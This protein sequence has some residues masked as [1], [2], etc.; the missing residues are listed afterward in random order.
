M[1]MGGC[2]TIKRGS[3]ICILVLSIISLVGSVICAVIASF[4]HMPLYAAFGWIHVLL[5]IYLISATS[6]Y[7]CCRAC[8]SKVTGGLAV[9]YC[10]LA[11]VIFIVLAT[12]QQSA[13]EHYCEGT[14]ECASISDWGDHD[15]ECGHK[16]SSFSLCWV[17]ET[18][19]RRR[20]ASATDGAVVSWY[21]PADGVPL[22]G[23]ESSQACESRGQRLCLYDEL[24]PSGEGSAPVG[25][26]SSHSDWMPFLSTTYGRRWMTGGCQVH[27]DLYDEGCHV[28]GCGTGSPC[29]NECCNHGWCTT[30]GVDGCSSTSGSFNGYS[31]SCKGSYACCSGRDVDVDADPKWYYSKWPD[32]CQDGGGGDDVCRAFRTQDDCINYCYQDDDDEQCEDVDDPEDCNWSIVTH[33]N[34]VAGWS[35]FFAGLVLFPTLVWVVLLFV[36]PDPQAAAPVTAVELPR[37]QPQVMMVSPVSPGGGQPQVIMGQPQIVQAGQAPVIM[38]QPQVAQGGKLR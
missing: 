28:H 23:L 29:A 17:P 5:L 2:C 8:G 4:T 30:P 35:T 27:E 16:T 26:P 3:G 31:G 32:D 12:G 19:D 18:D 25:M 7:V 38:G 13:M 11:F 9:G 15:P 24:C 10:V 33:V 1:P 22:S 21:E 6:A 37:M 34:A 20:L 14:V 36:V